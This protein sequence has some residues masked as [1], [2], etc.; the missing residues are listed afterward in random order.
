MTGPLAATGADGA[1]LAATAGLAA[2]LIAAG[3]LAVVL[4]RRRV[5][6]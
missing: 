4:R 3:A 1:G 6:A 5:H 2:A